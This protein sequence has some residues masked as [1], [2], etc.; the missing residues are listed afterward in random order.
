MVMSPSEMVDFFEN[1]FQLFHGGVAPAVAKRDY[2]LAAQNL[3]TA[4]E[5]HLMIALL[6]WRH[7]LGSP[8]KRIAAALEVAREA[9]RVLPDIDAAQ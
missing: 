3:S 8:V 2:H 7:R 1:Q 4:Y 5:A 9:A 6:Q